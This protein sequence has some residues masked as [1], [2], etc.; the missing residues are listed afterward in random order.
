[1]LGKH[2]R[3]AIYARGSKRTSTEY[4]ANKKTTAEIGGRSYLLTVAI[5]TYL[6]GPRGSFFSVMPGQLGANSALS[7]L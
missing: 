2:W 6:A 5:T 7:S 3:F 4:T 1:M